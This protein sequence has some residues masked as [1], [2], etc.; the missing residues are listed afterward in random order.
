[1]TAPVTRSAWLNLYKKL[2]T[3][4]TKF[5]DY[6]YREYAKRRIRDH[7]RAGEKDQAKLRALYEFGLREL[8]SLKRQTTLAQLYIS[9]KLIIENLAVGEKLSSELGKISDK[10]VGDLGKV[11]KSL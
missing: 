6:N 9:P 1:M 5:N 2:F 7:F 10:I 8:K 4:A 3:Q 11:G